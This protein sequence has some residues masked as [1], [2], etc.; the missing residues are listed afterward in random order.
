MRRPITLELIYQN[1]D[2]GKLM[3]LWIGE[4]GK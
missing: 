4:V 1:F 2:C 3:N